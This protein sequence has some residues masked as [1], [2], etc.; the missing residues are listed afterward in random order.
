MVLQYLR[1]QSEVRRTLT[2]LKTRA[3]LLHPRSGSSLSPPRGSPSKLTRVGHRQ[4]AGNR[5]RQRRRPPSA[6]AG[7]A[8]MRLRQGVLVTRARTPPEDHPS[9]QA[10]APP[11]ARPG[12]DVWPL[13]L[14]T[15]AGTHAGDHQQAA[16]RTEARQS[17]ATASWS[18]WD[19]IH[20]IPVP[21][22]EQCDL[23]KGWSM[24]LGCRSLIRPPWPWARHEG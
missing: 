11:T 17:M 16:Q 7:P 23:R 22:M 5:P 18:G 9:R 24:A 14:I 2:V 19:V 20:P 15:R 4:L 13:Q 3:G 12:S 8:Y 21:F 1:H 10:A 6:P